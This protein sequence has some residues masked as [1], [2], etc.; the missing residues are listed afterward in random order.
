MEQ[1]AIAPYRQV[2]LDREYLAG[3]A[4]DRYR[5]KHKKIVSNFSPYQKNC[6]LEDFKDHIRYL[7]ESLAIN[8]D[9]I[10]IDYVSWA[11]LIFATRHLPPDYLPS[12]LIA[13][14]EVLQKELPVD[15]RTK[16]ESFIKKSIAMPVHVPGEI[17]PYITSEKPLYRVAQSCLEALIAADRKKAW[18]VIAQTVTSGVPVR[19]IYLQVLQ[20]VLRETGRLWQIGKAGIAQEHY[21]TASILLFISRLHDQIHSAGSKP[22]RRGKTLVAGCVS[23]ELHDIGI[24]MVADFF[25]MDGWDTYYIGGNI[26]ARSLL[27]AVRDQHA[28]VV[29]LSSTMAFHLPVVNYLIRSLRADPTTRNVKIIVGGYPFNIVPDLWK[30]VDADAFAG[31]A[32]DAVAAANRLSPVHG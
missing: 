23:D 11:R 20:P 32:D 29:A 6:T 27:E 1:E 18:T 8:N 12:T 13:L 15:F 3:K 16:T 2:S 24:R 26:P 4:F 28:D 14:N 5:E 30:Q 21:V 7:Q 10:F 25:E 17:P 22:G 19:D 31:N 9:A